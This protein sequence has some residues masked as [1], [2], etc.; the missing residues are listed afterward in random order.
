M[1]YSTASAQNNPT[2][3]VT[4][5]VID[6]LTHEPVMYS[7]L[8][9]TNMETG[10]PVNGGLADD[11]GQFALEKIAKGNYILT[12]SFLDYKSRSVDIIINEEDQHIHLGT[13][14]LSVE[15]KNIKEIIVTGRKQL[16]EEKVDRTVYNAENDE[17]NKGGDATDVLRKVPMLSVDMDGN[18]SLRGS[19]N[20]MV[21]INGKPSTIT[22]GNLAD[23]L[24][25]IPAELIKSVEVITSPSVKYDAE[26][27]AGIIN[28][29]LK[30]NTLE[31]LTLNIDS[32]VGL[33]G[34]NL[35]LNGNYRKGKMAF[36][37]GGWG[38][39]GYNIKGR[40]KNTQ[41]IQNPDGTIS[42]NIQTASTRNRN[43]HGRYQ[44]GWEY[45]INK[46][47]FLSA[48]LR[49]S[50]HNNRV[51]Q[52][53]FLTESYS[54]K[55][56]QN[57]TLRDINRNNLSGT[58][59][60][61]LNYTHNFETPQ[62]EFSILGLYSRNIRDD[63][64]YNNIIN[65][66]DN[67]IQSRLRSQNDNYNEE[68][69]L[70]AD[71]ATPVGKSQIFESGVK[72]IWRNVGSRFTYYTAGPDGVFVPVERL[73]LNN[74]FNYYQNVNSVYL[75]HTISLPKGFSAK[76]GLR[77]E[78]TIISASFRDG[79]QVNIPSYGSLI[80]GIN[81]SKKLNNG[82]MIKASYNR[83]LQR[84]SLRYLNPNIEASNP[85]DVSVGNPLLDPEFT[86]NYEL[87]YNTFIES[88]SLNINAFV[89]NTNNAIQHVRDAIGE[90]TIRT[91]FQNIGKE[92]AYGIGVFTNIKLGEKLTVSGNTD[93][94][95]VL[96]NNNHP[97]PAYR[98]SNSG[99]VVSGRVNGTY[100]LT[101]DW[102]LQIFSFYR[103]RQIHLQG[104]R[105]GFGMYS[106]SLRKDFKNKKGS[107]GFGAENFF[108]PGGILVVNEVNTPTMNQRNKDV[109]YNMNFKV[110]LSYRIGKLSNSEGKPKKRKRIVNDDMK[111][112]G[113]NDGNETTPVNPPT[114]RN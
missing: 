73:E 62:R 32:S 9:L 17:T 95:Y 18:V 26:G 21:L 61:N 85:L 31:G 49:Y 74:R 11:L 66:Q 93:I 111:D 52:D 107:L 39:A 57:S 86:N 43:M 3:K 76:G 55:V 97:N 54:N 7:A 112:S 27:S 67:S 48:N 12:I 51:F 53:N 30:K 58:I 109:R 33:R 69:A 77:Y 56:F 98:A 110:N 42:E 94:Y 22:A 103:A 105:G 65:Q 35:G 79:Q 104:Y 16:I 108:H 87:G 91:T 113:G 75:S 2:G 50:F 72:S 82:G 70:Q 46:N 34:S 13:I 1:F 60:L 47:N 36:S 89:R 38:R 8:V 40:Y 63:N 10:K 24:R 44:L 59:D 20:L 100:K 84:P 114:K 99:F 23:A 90:D 102:S 15:R 83:R 101:E 64:F 80:P 96:L 81:L 88:S 92:S 106:L 6:S 19:Q 71:Y 14:L 5:V 78:Y 29:V 37:L 45:D 68:I 25:Q 41:T 28:I 4:G